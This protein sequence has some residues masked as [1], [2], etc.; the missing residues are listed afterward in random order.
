MGKSTRF[1]RYRVLNSCV[2]E[3]EI[4]AW[5]QRCSVSCGRINFPSISRLS[6]MVTVVGPND[7]IYH[8]MPV[9]VPA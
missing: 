5:I 8:G 1:L 4:L 3:G 6:W 9:I 7:G 2:L